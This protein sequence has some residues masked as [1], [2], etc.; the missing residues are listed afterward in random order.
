MKSEVVSSKV[1]SSLL[2]SSVSS[3]QPKAGKATKK[4]EDK[5]LVLSVPLKQIV[6]EKLG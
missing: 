3:V 6:F 4:G 1:D 2:Q 5:S